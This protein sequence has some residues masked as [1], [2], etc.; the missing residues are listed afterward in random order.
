MS[1][2]WINFARIGNPNGKGLPVWTPF[3]KNSHTT[4]ELGVN[5]E[6]TPLADPAKLSFWQAWLTKP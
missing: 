3:D 5:V 4:I 6:P 2:Y 1:S